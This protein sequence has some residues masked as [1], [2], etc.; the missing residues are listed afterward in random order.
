MI[1]RQ[2]YIEAVSFQMKNQ[3]PERDERRTSVNLKTE[4]R[5]NLFKIQVTLFSKRHSP[6]QTRL[7]LWG[8]RQTLTISHL[9]D[10]GNYAPVHHSTCAILKFQN[11]F[12][13]SALF[14]PQK[15]QEKGKG[16]TQSSLCSN[17][18]EETSTAEG[19]QE[20]L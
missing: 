20:L 9:S 1:E 14:T 5:E 8:G 17:R 11:I 2:C 7:L 10:T 3:D 13:V 19:F 15:P 16:K 18:E 12:N 4:V 6:D